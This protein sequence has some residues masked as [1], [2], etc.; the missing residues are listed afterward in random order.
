MVGAKTL[1]K[2]EICQS[3]PSNLSGHHSL[4]REHWGEWAPAKSIGEFDCQ[5]GSSSYRN[6]KSTTSVTFSDN[7]YSLWCPTSTG[8][9]VDPF[10][11]YANVGKEYWM[12]AEVLFE[13]SRNWPKFTGFGLE[14]Y[15]GNQSSNTMY[16]RR[17]ATCWM[18]KDG[19]QIYVASP[20]DGSNGRSDPNQYNYWGYQWPANSDELKTQDEGYIFTGFRFNYRS[21]SGT[22]GGSIK[23][24]S[25]FNLKMYTD[26]PDM[27]SGTRVVL[28][29]MMDVAPREGETT[30]MFEPLGYGDA[31]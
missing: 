5:R 3:K 1:S 13:T 21:K 8:A 27:Q 31:A 9:D 17:I 6:F 10:K 4:H 30:G 22:G 2:S 19:D 14:S 23:T 15:N 28:P 18:N 25:I 11:V 24:V 29:R 16:L 26:I 20:F 12:N 7:D